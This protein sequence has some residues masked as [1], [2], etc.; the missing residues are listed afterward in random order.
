[1]CTSR[2]TA[3][4]CALPNS[5][6]CFN[7]QISDSEKTRD[8]LH[9]VASEEKIRLEALRK[10]QKTV[11][12]LKEKLGDKP[13]PPDFSEINERNV[14]ARRIPR[15]YLH[16]LTHS[17]FTLA[18]HHCQASGNPGGVHHFASRR[19]ALPP[20]PKRASQRGRKPQQPVSNSRPRLLLC[21]PC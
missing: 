20:S 7:D 18:P 6:G 8:N 4:N 9:S 2:S 13:P 11:H 10:L 15:T 16:S 3:Q 17:S 19:R 5:P 21:P 12:A 14:S 1:M